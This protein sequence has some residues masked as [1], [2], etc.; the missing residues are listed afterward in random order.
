[1]LT[2]SYSEYLTATD[3]PICQLSNWVSTDFGEGN[4][5]LSE[6]FRLLGRLELLVESFD[7]LKIF[8]AEFGSKISTKNGSPEML[9]RNVQK[10]I[11]R[12]LQEGKR[13]NPGTL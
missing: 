11:V 4:Y 6:K 2:E 3:E 10:A 1:M 12:V 13:M 8:D 9:T 7:A 5:F